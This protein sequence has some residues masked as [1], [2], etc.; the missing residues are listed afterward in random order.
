MEVLSC[1]SKYD[2]I[3]SRDTPFVS[4]NKYKQK[5]A[6]NTH[7]KV[8]I[9]QTACNPRV[10]III[11]YNLMI[12]NIKKYPQLCTTPFIV[13]KHN[14]KMVKIEFVHL[15]YNFVKKKKMVTKPKMHFNT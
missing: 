9:D 12:I 10:D 7:I 1:D 14:N 2:K 5:N 8:N 15:M 11:G 4:G 6:L 13:P 3:S